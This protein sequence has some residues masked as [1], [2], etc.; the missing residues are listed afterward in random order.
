MPPGGKY[1][2]PR[3]AEEFAVAFCYGARQISWRLP[4]G[5]EM[6]QQN[7][8]PRRANGTW[9]VADALELYSVP[10]WGSGYFS[11]NEAGNVV[12]RPDGTTAHEIDLLEVVQGL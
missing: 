11:I 10:D 2:A 8:V 4:D 6:G 1:P 7:S 5:V 12:V 9:S 3:T